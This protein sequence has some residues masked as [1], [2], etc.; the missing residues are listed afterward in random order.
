[1]AIRTFNPF[2]SDEEISVI[3]AGLLDR[4]LPKA[5]WTHAAH[6]AATLW[7]LQ[8]RPE[9][10]IAREMPGFIRG[11]NEAIGGK[12]TD[13][14]G[15]HETITQ[16]SIRA[17]RAFVAEAPPQPLFV[18]CNTLMRSRFGDPEW[19]MEYW[20]RPRLFSVAARRAWL[21]PDLR[22]LPF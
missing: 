17:A 15:Y 11:Y 13:T 3:G 10:D 1:M 14:S 2:T 22:K 19:L 6:F 8:C 9:I 4:T 12:N 18:T 20:T 16:A 7:L 21:E 5:V